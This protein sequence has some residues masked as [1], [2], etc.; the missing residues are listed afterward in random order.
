MWAWQ[1]LN[2]FILRFIALGKVG[3]KEKKKW[4]Y[5][6]NIT[7]LKNMERAELVAQ[8]VGVTEIPF[9]QEHIEIQ[10]QG[11]AQ[12]FLLFLILNVKCVDNDFLAFLFF[13]DS[14]QLVQS[15]WLLL[16]CDF[17]ALALCLFVILDRTGLK[18]NIFVRNLLFPF[19]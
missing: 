17:K 8:P 14:I 3:N 16:C 12:E 18:K 11:P 10:V 15:S 6:F 1:R 5:A 7:P 9:L 2:S 19:K 4:L 13:Y